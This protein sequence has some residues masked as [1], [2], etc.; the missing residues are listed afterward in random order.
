K[1]DT[2]GNIT[3]YKV[4]LIAQGFIQ[5]LGLGYTNTFVLASKLKSLHVLLVL[6]AYKN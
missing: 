2:K 6:M 5:V 4:W 3:K 1:H